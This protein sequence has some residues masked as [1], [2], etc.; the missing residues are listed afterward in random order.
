MPLILASTSPRRHELLALLGIPFEAR[1]PSFEER[2]VPDRPA[3][4]QV[5]SFAQGKARSVA[6]QEPEAI[7][8]GSDTVIELDH[9]VLGKPA[10]LAEARAML[11]C[12]AGRDHQ[13]RTAVALVCSACATDV[14][15]LSTAVVRM[16]PFDERVH[17]HYLATGESLGKAGAY[18]IQGE[19]GDLIDSIDGDFP[20]VVGLPL[21]L[22]AQ[23]LT[24]V[25]VSVPADL[26]E[27]YATKP[28]ANWARF[29]G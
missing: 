12:L 21:R 1:S 19:G 27:L 11:R 17:E 23:L 20:T 28:Y 29:P 3:I 8:L 14:V 4:E 7:V 25:G 10:D 2:L 18:S 16:K 5:Q 24:Q 26:D 9:A 22:V 15:A 13:V 6:R